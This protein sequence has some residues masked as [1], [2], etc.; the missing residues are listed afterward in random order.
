M[1][2]D[3]ALDL[4]ILKEVAAGH[5][6]AR[7]AGAKPWSTPSPCFVCRSAGRV[8]RSASSGPPIGTCRG[9]IRVASGC[10][11]DHRTSQGVRPVWVQNGDGYATARGLG[12]GERWRVHNVAARRS[13]SAHEAAEAGP[14][15]ACRWVVP[16][17]AA[18]VPPSRLVV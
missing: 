16:P 9:P 5:F 2:A 10:A 3:Q 6:S 14:T 15:L 12:R 1:L 7:P 18:C 8:G 11:A 13:P 17:T 4:S